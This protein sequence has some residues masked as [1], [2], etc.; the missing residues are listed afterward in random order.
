MKE[1]EQNLIE[2]ART[3]EDNFERILNSTFGEARSTRLNKRYGQAFPRAYKEDVLPSVAISDINQ[4][5]SLDDEHKLGMVLYRAQEEKDDSKYLRLKLF[6]KDQP[7]HLSDVLPMLENFGLRVIGESPYPV[8][9]AD[10]NVFWILDFHMIHTGGALDLE[11]S[12]ELFKMR[13]Q[14]FGKVNLKMMA[15]TGSY[16]VPV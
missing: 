1:L 7:I 11:T 8:K 5:E 4:L 6:H 14:K 10:G 16:L 13:L 9:A 15:L 2:A 3:W 12:R